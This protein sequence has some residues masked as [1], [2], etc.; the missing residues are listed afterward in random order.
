MVHNVPEL[1]AMGL[2]CK[3]Y[4]LCERTGR[5]H[6]KWRPVIADGR[7]AQFITGEEREYPVGFCTK[8]AQSLPQISSFLEI[9]SGP[10]AP[11][12]RA[13]SESR[14]GPEVAPRGDASGIR[15]GQDLSH[16]S[17]LPGQKAPPDVPVSQPTTGTPAG[18][19]RPK[20]GNHVAIGSSRQ[21]GFGR[22]QQL[23]PDGLQDPVKHLKMAG[24]LE[25]PFRMEG[26]LKE[27]HRAA[28][29]WEANSQDPD[30]ER[31]RLLD[32]LRNLK[33]SSRV[34]RRDAELKARASDAARR[35]GQKMDLGL[36]EAAQELAG[37]E[38]LAV[39]LLCSVG[40]PI[41]GPASESPFFDHFPEP[42]KVT[43][44]EFGN[45]CKRRRASAVRRTKFMAEK[46]GD[47]MSTAL[48]AKVL[49][50]V[51]D[52]SMGPALTAGEA[53]RLYGDHFNAIPSFGLRQ[54]LNSKGEPKFRRIDDHTA[55]WVNLAAKRMQKIQ[56]A[57]ADYIAVMIKQTG[58]SFP[59]EEVL[60]G[61]ADMKAA[62]RQIPLADADVKNSITC[63]YNPSSRDV[64]FHAMYGQPF[65]AG[66]A[67]PNFYRVAEWFSR[68]LCRY[69]HLAVDHFFDD[70]WI[71]CSRARSQTAMR[72][73]LESAELLGIIFDPDK[74]QQPSSHTEALGVIFN[75][76]HLHSQ[77]RLLV[78]P[79]ASRIAK[80]QA[81]IDGVLESNAITSSEAASL[82][83]KFGFLASTL[84]GKVGRCAALGLRARQH[85]TSESCE[86][87]PAVTTS[88]RLM[89]IFAGDAPAREVRTRDPVPPFLL[90]SDASD[91]PERDRRYGIGAV[92]VDQRVL[93]RLFQFALEVPQ[94]TVG[95]WLPKKTF[96]GQL[97]IYAGPTALH[98][99]ADQLTGQHVIHFVDNDSASACLVR[100]YSPKADSC[101]LVGLYWLS[102]ARHRVASYIDRVESKSN[103]ADG[104][105]RFDCD[106]LQ[107]LGSTEVQPII[108]PD[109]DPAVLN[110]WFHPGAAH[111]VATP[112]H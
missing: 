100:G 86:L 56:M 22:R 44:R 15:E 98:T 45:T 61:T 91:V 50:E 57:N 33:A 106:L 12:S 52:G 101:E 49:Q 54:G 59:G 18:S 87:D 108:P 67:V 88:L 105:S 14:G 72:C 109:L 111:P 29:R 66:H 20:W 51:Q 13:V 19:K 43:E 65:G 36:M 78:E 68:F 71:V 64:D 35:L 70:F 77:G 1:N 9:Y 95:R 28:L 93:P 92:L 84:F 16:A 89:R 26:A 7:V 53:A 94:A 90:S 31:L 73:L 58:E 48:H 46:G 23:I 104:P 32:E 21:P 103:L 62:Y 8:Y 25:H 55:G 42:Q 83:G 60:V 76:L 82:L 47:D 80:L 37:I 112:G 6:E 3:N 4:R 10:N 38:D 27:D 30:A 85:S 79:K 107:K 99:W 69:F 5:P 24:Q 110:T 102:A 75:T 41:T 34:R 11:L 17:S 97:E 39:P 74:T 2:L 96:M 81:T 40:M 63:V